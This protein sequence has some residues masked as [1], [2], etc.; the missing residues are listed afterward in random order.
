MNYTAH[1]GKLKFLLTKIIRILL[2]CAK[3]LM[4]EI[5][6]YLMANIL[7]IRYIIHYGQGERESLCIFSIKWTE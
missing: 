3:K 5:D 1:A 6:L 2:K 7:M 4:K